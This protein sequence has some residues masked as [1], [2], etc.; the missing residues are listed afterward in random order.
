MLLV[1]LPGFIAFLTK[2]SEGEENAVALD[3]LQQS[4]EDRKDKK[5]WDH[6]GYGGYGGG[7]HGGNGDYE[8]D[9]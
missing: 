6:D 1:N 2:C 4:G 3:G 5:D 7:G 8:E 9:W